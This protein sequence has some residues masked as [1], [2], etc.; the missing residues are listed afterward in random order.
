MDKESNLQEDPNN[1]T[2]HSRTNVGCTRITRDLTAVRTQTTLAKEKTTI[3]DEV[4]S[5]EGKNIDT[6]VEDHHPYLHQVNTLQV[7]RHI[8]ENK[9]TATV[10][11]DH[12]PHL[13]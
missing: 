1:L 5:E 11:G 7:H 6:I 2:K 9:N 10:V 13:Y 4:D 12:H 8:D 3:K